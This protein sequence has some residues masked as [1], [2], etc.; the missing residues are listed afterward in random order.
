MITI[1]RQILAKIFNK[2]KNFN[3]AGRTIPKIII[4]VEIAALSN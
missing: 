4:I 2:Y 1:M 3:E